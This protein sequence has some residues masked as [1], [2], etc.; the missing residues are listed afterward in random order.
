MS[1]A[2][3]TAK[4]LREVY[5]GG[6]WTCVNLKDALADVSQNE[7]TT[8]LYSFNTIITLVFH[9]N[10]YAEAII[11]VLQGEPLN[12]KDELSFIHPPV[13]SQ[14]EWEKIRART[15][16]NAENLAALIELQPDTI[17]WEE[18]TD[19]KYQSY[20]RNLHGMIEHTHYH[21]GQIVILKKLL[22]E[23]DQKGE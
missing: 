13:N 6:N 22:R 4:H 21:L 5:F 2:K 1:L 20:F 8:K 9:M 15:L 23:A 7:A 11:R 16:D 14:E 10:Y 19:P 3:Q 18:F 17:F 12:A